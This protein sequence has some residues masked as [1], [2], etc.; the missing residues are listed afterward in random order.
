MN[1]RF[2]LL[3]LVALFSIS[4]CT[5]RVADMTVASTKNADINSGA[6]IIGKRVYGRDT[7]PVVLVPLGMPSVKEAMDNAIEV[8]RCAVALTNVTVDEK[9]FSFLIGMVQYE[10]EG[11]LVIDSSVN[12][13]GGNYSAKVG[14]SNIDFY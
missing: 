4:G 6:F 10:V 13:C 1:K 2:I 7:R 14:S 9:I 8:D 11:N 12:G 3:G 5:T